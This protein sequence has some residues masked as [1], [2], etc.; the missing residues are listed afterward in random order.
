[1]T[2]TADPPA[3]GVKLSRGQVV[4]ALSGLMMG[5]FVAI[6]A[7]TVVAN[8]L[9]RIVADLGGSQ[10]SYT[11]VVTTELLAMTATV[12]LWGKLSDLYNKKLL[13]QLSLLM[14]VIGSLVAGFSQDIGTL[15]ASRVVQGVGAGGLTALVSVVM[16][17]M[18]SPRELGRYMGI[19][20]AVFAV[21]TVAGPLI[22]GV[23]VDTSWL[24][25]RWCFFLGVPFAALAILLLQ[26]T[27]K[28]PTVKREGVKV[29]YLGAFLIMLGV[30]TLLV[31]TSLAG[32][33]F[34]WLSGW[35]FFLVGAGVVV[36]ALAVWVESRVAEPIVPLSIFRNRTVTL[37]TI[38]SFLVGVA[39]FGGTV[40]LSQYFQLSLGKSPTVAGLMGLPM[41]FGLLVSSTVSGQLISKT[42]KWKVYLV[43]GGILMVAGFALLATIDRGTSIVLLSAY[44]VVLGIGVGMLMQNLVLVAQNDVAAHDL[45]AS[46]S[47]LTFFRSLGGTVGVSV[48]GAVLANRLTSEVTSHLGPLPDGGGTS[49]VPDL[50]LLPPEIAAVFRDAYGVATSSIFLYCLPFAALAVLVVFFIKQIP[51][52][53]QTGD[54]RLAQES[55]AAAA[56][57]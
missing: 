12:P 57:D 45:G 21:G 25:W 49:A 11:W 31:W 19:F 18:V 52:K 55:A 36:L 2:V 42:G 13:I 24:G 1:M 38:V 14:F 3:D 6:L 39:M 44:M 23:M 34:D 56:A 43:L 29:D 35:S 5:L 16:A 9:P 32:H 40:F 41:I 50:N 26:R 37:T 22:G 54:E 28:L 15:I 33:Q 20:G 8:A 17:A 51:L 48:L 47:V 4:Q 53:T 10:S 7:G 30:S 27:L 46:T